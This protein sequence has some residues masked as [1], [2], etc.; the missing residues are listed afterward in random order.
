CAF[1]KSKVTRGRLSKMELLKFLVCFAALAMTMAQDKIL[2]INEEDLESIDFD[3]E[4]DDEQMVDDGE[5]VIIEHDEVPGGI[6]EY[7][8]TKI[9]VLASSINKFSIVLYNHLPRAYRHQVCFGSFS[10]MN[11]M[12]L[13]YIGSA[14]RTEEEL[15]RVLQ[16]KFAVQTKSLISETFSQANDLLDSSKPRQYM[17]N[18]SDTF[19][20]NEGSRVNLKFRS[21]IDK[22]LVPVTVVSFEEKGR[23]AALAINH[24]LSARTK[25]Y[26]NEVLSKVD[27]RS[28]VIAV[29]VSYIKGVWKNK[30]SSFNTEK[31]IFYNK[32]SSTNDTIVPMMRMTSNLEYF[33]DEWLTMVALPIKG[34]IFS[35]YF[36]LP[37]IPVEAPPTT[38]N[39]FHYAIKE[40]AF[41]M[42]LKHVTVTIPKFRFEYAL[43]VSRS[44]CDMGV[45]TLC[46]RGVFNLAT[47]INKKKV[48]VGG[49]IHKTFV[50]ISEAGI[51]LGTHRAQRFVDIEEANITFVVDRPFQ[52][53]II[54]SRSGMVLFLGSVDELP[55]HTEEKKK[56]N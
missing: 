44:L 22:F 50:D 24:W 10:I 46:R 12:S 48:T 17:F 27:P 21:E 16:Y 54:D 3:E 7:T 31:K 52:F 34:D 18:R 29:D 45:K 36:L 2:V 38:L 5:T 49:I 23:I 26:L 55:K 13:L 51:N 33:D 11:I 37:K 15:K 28:D 35:V 41:R 8:P 30:F 53:S 1:F 42:E 47:M 43:N 14:G 6:I 39:I 19:L 4:K 56:G 40:A 32:G 20:F 9:Q 25:G